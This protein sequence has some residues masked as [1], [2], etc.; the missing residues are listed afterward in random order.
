VKKEQNLLR[1]FWSLQ[2]KSTNCEKFEGRKQ[3]GEEKIEKRSI[4]KKSEKRPSIS[5][6]TVK[7]PMNIA[8]EGFQNKGR[9]AASSPTER[10]KKSRRGDLGRRKAL[11][12]N[13]I[14]ENPALTFKAKRW[15][16]RCVKDVQSNGVVLSRRHLKWEGQVGAPRRRGAVA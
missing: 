1:L 10:K 4:E 7:N 6:Y 11:V 15:E 8:G 12:A 5:C 3:V 13:L 9:G 14:Q 16:S 2:K